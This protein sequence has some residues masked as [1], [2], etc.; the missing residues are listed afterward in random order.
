[1]SRRVATARRGADVVATGLDQRVA[2]GRILSIIRQ[3]LKV[4]GYDVSL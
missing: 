2:G 3:M 4:R 1:M